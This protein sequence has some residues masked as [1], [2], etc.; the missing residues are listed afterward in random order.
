MNPRTDSSKE[1][2]GEN[3]DFIITSA[4]SKTAVSSKNISGNALDFILNTVGRWSLE[5][6]KSA[7]CMIC[8]LSLKPEQRITKCPMCESM[9]HQDHIV[10]WLKM[11]GKCPVCQQNLRPES[12]QRVKL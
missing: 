9:F 12:L 7:I 11:K 1:I 4:K 3:I 10:D 8:K 5:E 6:K 2:A